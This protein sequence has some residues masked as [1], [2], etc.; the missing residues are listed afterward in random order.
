MQLFVEMVGCIASSII[1]TRGYGSPIVDEPELGLGH[2]PGLLNRLKLLHLGR[3]QQLMLGEG[4]MV[5]QA[6]LLLLL[7][8]GTPIV[9]G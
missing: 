7:L 9:N 2:L 8:Y 4:R 3:F 5:H 6:S 1:G